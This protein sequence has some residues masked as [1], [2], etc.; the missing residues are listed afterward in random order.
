MTTFFLS[1]AR[2]DQGIALRLADDL[3][4]AGVSVWV[5]Q[6][7]IQPSQ[8]WDRAVEAAVRGC[9][10]FIAVLSPAAV[11]SPNVADEASVAIDDGKFIIPVLVERCTLPLR[12]TRMQYI[13]ATADYDAA[14]RRCLTAIRGAAPGPPEPLSPSTVL[15]PD[16][17]AEVERRL[18]GFIGP[19][20][21][22]LV[23]QAARRAQTPE[24]L[25]SALA[26]NLSDPVERKAFLGWVASPSQ[27][28]R[29]VTARTKA[30]APTLDEA[31]VT[32]L[33]QALIHYLGPIAPQL[34]RRE[35]MVATTYP[36]LC[37]RLAARIPDQ[38]D[39]DAFLKQAVKD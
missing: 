9:H 34:V 5:D 37:N 12:M 32:R 38:R 24:A 25:Y 4:G 27:R 35:A 20:A 31:T 13:D 33:V 21:P 8:H 2:L 16:I 15:S 11:A 22:H 10:G 1:Y 7:D 28:G 19:I 14:L 23:K 26:T 3:I 6:Y 17:L 29:V 36:D 30:A 39:R 18:T